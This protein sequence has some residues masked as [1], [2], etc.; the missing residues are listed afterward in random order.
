VG[1]THD[2]QE[3]GNQRPTEVTGRQRVRWR[4][5]CAY[6]GTRGCDRTCPQYQEVRDAEIRFDEAR[7]ATRRMAAVPPALIDGAGAEGRRPMRPRSA[8]PPA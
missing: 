3:L 5:R 2:N 1:G 7:A 4:R 6:C 8:L